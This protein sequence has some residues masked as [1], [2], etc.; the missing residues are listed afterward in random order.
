[1]WAIIVTKYIGNLNQYIIFVLIYLLRVLGL[2][3]VVLKNPVN[4][5]ANISSF[6]SFSSLL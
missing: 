3:I 5:V 4:F 6:F 2:S 1:M